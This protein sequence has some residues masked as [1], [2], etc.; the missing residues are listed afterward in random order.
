MEKTIE[1]DISII[2]PVNRVEDEVVINDVPVEDVPVHVS[3]ST[4][5]DGIV[6]PRVV[7]VNVDQVQG[8][9]R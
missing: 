5:V 1:S 7:V 4:I 3:D 9:I 6:D 2:N 8:E